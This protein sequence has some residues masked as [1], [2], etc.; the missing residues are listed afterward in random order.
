M[1]G[2]LI[3]DENG[4]QE[5]V[6]YYISKQLSGPALKYNHEEKMA[7]AVIHSIQKLCH[8][9]LLL[10]TWVVANSNPMQYILGHYP[11]NGKYARWVVILQE[12]DLT[13]S[14]PKSKKALAITEM[15]T[16]LPSG[17]RDPLLHN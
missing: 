9:I 6:V 12:Y 7:L 10:Q 14:T 4:R 16:D 8:Y 17:T 13:F 15:I 2:V 3:Q 5:H 1:V 11:L